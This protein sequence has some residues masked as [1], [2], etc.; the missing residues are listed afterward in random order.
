MNERALWR[1]AIY[2]SMYNVSNILEKACTRDLHYFPCLHIWKL[3]SLQQQWKITIKNW[4][5]TGTDIATTFKKCDDN[6]QCVLL[7]CWQPLLIRFKCLL[8]WFV[9]FTIGEALSSQFSGKPTFQTD[10]NI[11][12]FPNSMKKSVSLVKLL[13]FI[14]C[15]TF[16]ETE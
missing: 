5:S 8:R 4:I 6:L 14:I 10:D 12:R 7:I 1:L 16:S 15:K 2:E 9:V 11:H 13:M 3:R